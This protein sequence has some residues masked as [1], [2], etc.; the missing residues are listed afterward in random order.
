[1]TY[2]LPSPFV[3]DQDAPLLEGPQDALRRNVRIGVIAVAALLLGVFGVAALV[4]ITGAVIGYGEVSVESRIKKIAHPTGGVIAEVLVR[5]GD[6]VRRGQPLMRLDTTVS[7]VSASTSGETFEQLLARRARLTAERDGMGAVAWPQ[8]LLKS[9][10]PSAQAAV[11]EESRLFAIRR[12]ARINEQAQYQERI[13]QTQ[14]QITSLEAQLTAARQQSSLIEPERAGV[15]K[16]WEKGLVTLN[17]VNQL[18]RTAVD[19]EGGA[20]SLRAQIA[21]ARAHIA[22]I[23][24]SSMQ[25]DQAARSQA[26]VELAQTAADLNEQQVRKVA[27]G[28][29]Y[30]RSIVRAPAAG[31]VDKLAFA[32]IGGVV[33]PAQTIM[34][35]V[36]DEDRMVV[37]ARV[38][39]A[40]IDQLHVGQQAMLRF[41]AFNLQT[42][43][44]IEGKL[45][46]IAAERTVDERSGQSF[47][48]V[49]LEA[50]D[51]QLRKL[52]ELKLVPGMPVEA[53]IQTGDRSLLSYITKPLRDQLS[54]SFR[55]N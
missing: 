3:A 8:E 10:A 36:P 52:G 6:R 46:R 4:Q 41:S 15:K 40:D 2:Q 19:L 39:T 25:L 34:E 32:T 26:G 13:R 28:D 18:E 50:N 37:E 17:K 51:D 20:A 30:D 12:M 27:A 49:R 44:E 11:A 53:F 22:E 5:E 42:T 35:V 48:T 43:P 23:R 31:V 1:M 29:T 21:Q 9:T 47:Y 24:Q 14:Q 33:P 45:T 54:R 55:E 7:G 38:N 16:L